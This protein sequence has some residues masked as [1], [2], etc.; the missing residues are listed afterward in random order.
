MLEESNESEQIGLL[1]Q[2]S[3]THRHGTVTNVSAEARRFSSQAP[4]LQ[5]VH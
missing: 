3:P 5:G 2:R 1:D 4:R